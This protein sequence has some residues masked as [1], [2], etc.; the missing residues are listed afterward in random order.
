MVW[1][2]MIFSDLAA[3]LTEMIALTAAQEMI[4]F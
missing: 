1:V 2:V 3:P 4:R